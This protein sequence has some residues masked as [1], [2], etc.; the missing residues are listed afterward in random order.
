[1]VGHCGEVCEDRPHSLLNVSD[2]SSKPMRLALRDKQRH[3]VSEESVAGLAVHECVNRS[4]Q[5]RGVLP[6]GQH[7]GER[8]LLH[9]WGQSD[10]A[11]VN[12]VVDGHC[13]V[14]VLVQTFAAVDS[15]LVRAVVKPKGVAVGPRR[16]SSHSF[17]HDQVVDLHACPRCNHRRKLV[18]RMFVNFRFDSCPFLD[19]VDDQPRF[20]F[21][22]DK[23]IPKA[24]AR[25]AGASRR[26]P[27]IAPRQGF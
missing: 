20:A 19:V 13:C 6:T 11:Q 8:A 9:H 25:S 7:S 18:E 22:L 14:V 5:Q 17:R 1:M 26:Q 10:H 27:Q 16:Q 24:V 15:R 21:I 23:W 12:R 2:F 4:G 3:N